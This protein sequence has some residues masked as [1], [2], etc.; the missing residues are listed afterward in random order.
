MEEYAGRVLAERYRLPRPPADEFELVETRAFDTYSGQEVLVHQVLL[1]DVVTAEL[2]GEGRQSAD[3][4]GLGESARRA[5]DAA[6]AA[7]AIPDHP[8]L[9]QVFDIFVEGGSL[10]IASELV[11]AR[12]L[13]AYLADRPLDAYRAAEVASDVLAALRALHTHG[14]THRNVT[15]STVLLCDDGRAMLGGLASGAAQEALCGYDPLPEQV[16][17]GGAE[18]SW[19]GPESALEQ[20]RARQNRITVVGA[21][22]ERWAPEQAHEVHENWRLS[23]PVGPP[24]DLWAL[25]SLLFRS[26]QGHPPYPEDS[27]AELVQLVCAEPPAY[28]EECGPLRPIV[29]SLLRP[30]PEERPEAEEL[31]GWLRSLI[32]SAP[33]PELGTETVQLPADPTKLPIKRR[34]GE[35]VR[36]RRARA[37]A[38]AAAADASAA[39]HRRH[40]RGKQAKAVKVKRENARPGEPR[41]EQLRQEQVVSRRPDRPAEGGP[42]R[43]GARLLVAVLVVLA[44]VVLYAMLVLP[45]KSDSTDSNGDRPV[46][47]EMPGSGGSDHTG[48]SPTA[49]PT[50]AKP[51]PRPTPKPT[52]KAPTTP[53]QHTA[54]PPTAPPDLGADFAM[55]TDS[56]GFTVAVHTGWAR[57][58]KNAKDEV[59]FTGSDLGLTVVPGRDKAS[60]DTSDPL[61]YQLVEPELADFRAS[62]WSSAA[63]L[64]ALTLRGHPAAEG[65]YTWRDTNEQSVYARNLAV[66]I[67]GHYHVVLIIGPDAERAAV[68][69]AFDK[70]VETYT[71]R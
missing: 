38:A 29:E 62:S 58:G 65:E 69:R 37:A 31:G 43:L 63:G 7:A 16:L 47:A 19:H 3:P 61:A 2:P 55:H 36:R 20:E 21:V 39:T 34:R 14:W 64:Q 59:R 24:A 11:S 30:D 41:Q 25:G 15:A 52:T 70:A 45:H 1:P 28:A 56:A 26:V 49:R 18:S 32:R 67:N 27:A 46:P 54:Q 71:P 6:R 50:T 22:T 35:L 60:G 42:R 9:V 44:A 4:E 40:A 66:L 53:P 17:A 68:Q 12:P 10:W 13:A 5:L 23:P 51:S 8:R 48:K 33:E 57:S